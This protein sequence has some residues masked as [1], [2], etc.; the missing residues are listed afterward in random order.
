MEV[1][2]K[3][4]LTSTPKSN[5]TP[6]KDSEKK[7]REKVCEKIAMMAEKKPGIKRSE[8]VIFME[9]MVK[10]VSISNLLEFYDLD[11]LF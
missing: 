11:E 1:T 10:N 3:K 2:P 9:E 6:C 8:S 7:I 5:K 4:S